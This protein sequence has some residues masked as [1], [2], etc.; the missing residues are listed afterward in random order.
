MEHGIQVDI[1]FIEMAS[2]DA[3]I[4]HVHITTHG[5]LGGTWRKGRGKVGSEPLGKARHSHWPIR[6]MKL[7]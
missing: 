2:K 5:L 7:A 1:D 6:A 3:S 4:L